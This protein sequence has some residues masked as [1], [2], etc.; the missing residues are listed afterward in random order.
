MAHLKGVIWDM[1]ALIDSRKFWLRAHS[2]ALRMRRHTPTEQEILEMTG[3]RT[4][5]V[6][7]HWK[8][9][10][11]LDDDPDKLAVE[12]AGY[13][14]QQIGAAGSPHPGIPEVLELFTEFEIPMAVASLAPPEVINAVIDRLRLRGLF[15]VS[16]SATYELC[17][18]LHLGMYLTAARRLGVDCHDCLALCG[19]SS[20]V[21]AA[22]AAG[23]KCI[24]I[25]EEANFRHPE[26]RKADLVVH[27]L[28]G[29]NWD[30]ALSLF[31]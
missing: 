19:A 13:V 14:V 30:L 23:M 11:K 10:F 9:R 16:Y 22:L 6:A 2:E 3:L 12:I 1:D 31:P 17:S 5:E 25:P 8:Q 27:S 4:A 21:Q 15:R 7:W 26:I 29:V 24:A 20:G 28:E 18:N